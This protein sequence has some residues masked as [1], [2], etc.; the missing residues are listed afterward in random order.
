ML[1]YLRIEGAQ[2]AEIQIRQQACGLWRAY[3]TRSGV[4]LFGF[5]PLAT[6]SPP[7]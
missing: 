5:A 7:G 6:L 2:H 3:E 4:R 1:D